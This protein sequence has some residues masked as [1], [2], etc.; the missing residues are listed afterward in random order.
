[1]HYISYRRKVQDFIY[2]LSI[3]SLM[4][5]TMYLM[6]E[7]LFYRANISTTRW[8]MNHFY[9]AFFAFIGCFWTTFIWS[10][11]VAL[12]IGRQLVMQRTLVQAPVLAS[13]RL[14]EVFQSKNAESQPI[15]YTCLSTLTSWWEDKHST[16]TMINEASNYYLISAFLVAAKLCHLKFMLHLFSSLLFVNPL[17]FVEWTNVSLSF[18]VRCSV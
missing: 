5:C 18:C 10:R 4:V 9:S 16:S 17:G 11:K 1:M 6:Y 3:Y 15:S 13:I 14:T 12:W 8:D 7:R 2:L